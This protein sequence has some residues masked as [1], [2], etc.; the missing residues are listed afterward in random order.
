MQVVKAFPYLF[1]PKSSFGTQTDFRE[2]EMQTVPCSLEANVK[3]ELGALGILKYGRGLPV[4]NSE[5]LE[6][7]DQIREQYE[8]EKTL[9][10]KGDP[11]RPI[12]Q[13]KIIESKHQIEMGLKEK[14][15]SKVRHWKVANMKAA[16][17]EWADFSASQLENRLDRIWKQKQKE[18]DERMRKIKKIHEKE[19]KNLE[20]KCSIKNERLYGRPPDRRR[21]E[22]RANMEKIMQQEDS[23]MEI[24]GLLNVESMFGR[25]R[26][27]S[28]AKQRKMDREETDNFL[29]MYNGLNQLEKHTNKKLSTVT[30]DAKSKALF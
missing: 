12:L 22:F 14:A 10:P 18:K 13:R 23:D 25:P 16:V 4:Q 27:T 5:D 8:K 26:T 2:S 30:L 15:S 11:R 17:D 20:W 1:Q 7:V 6:V 28:S 3:G 21:Q 9:P 29:K 24:G 19:I